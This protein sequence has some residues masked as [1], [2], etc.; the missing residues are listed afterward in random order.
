[1]T[2]ILRQL[3]PYMFNTSSMTDIKDNAKK[4]IS[5]SKTV[6]NKLKKNVDDIFIPKYK[7]TLFWC[8]YIITK[9]WDAFYLV[10]RNSFS[11]EKECKIS[12]IEM[13]RNNKELLK[14]K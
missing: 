12:H 6:D 2:T 9:G 8:F 13:L 4:S 1:M 5:K 3:T 10:G 11:I 7:D 14:K